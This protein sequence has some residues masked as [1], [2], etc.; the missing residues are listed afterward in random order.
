MDGLYLRFSNLSLSFSL[1][2]I[3]LLLNPVFHCSQGSI[4]LKESLIVS[5]YKKKVISDS[6]H[7]RVSKKIKS[8]SRSKRMNVLMVKFLMTLN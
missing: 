4:L 7:F 3:F 5:G 2:N 8:L 1:R 6:P